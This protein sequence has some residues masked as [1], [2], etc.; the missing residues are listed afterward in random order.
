MLSPV[1]A[2]PMITLWI[3]D[4]PSN[5]VRLVDEGGSMTERAVLG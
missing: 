2:L 3:S 5:I 1:T 4:V